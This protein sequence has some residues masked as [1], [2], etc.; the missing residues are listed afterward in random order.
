MTRVYDNLYRSAYRHLYKSALRAVA[1]SVPARYIIKAELRKAFRTG[2][3]SAVDYDATRI[4]NTV[5]FF[6][7][8]S[9][10]NWIEHKILKNLI[11]VRYWERENT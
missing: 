2:G 3:G 11:H 10:A 9:K 1:Y 7:Q 8:A 5:E 4:A 6:N